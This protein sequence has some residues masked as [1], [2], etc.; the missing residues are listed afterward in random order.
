MK[1]PLSLK[2]NNIRVRILLKFLLCATDFSH[3]S[4]PTYSY[5]P[6]QH[7]WLVLFNMLIDNYKKKQQNSLQEPKYLELPIEKNHKA[8]HMTQ[9]N[10]TYINHPISEV[11]IIKIP[12]SCTIIIPPIIILL[13]CHISK[14]MLT[15]MKLIISSAY[16]MKLNP[17]L[18]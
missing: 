12:L 2:D 14:Q 15:K 5:T 1:C 11:I 9:T 7:I 3:T 13:L 6:F 16:T 10:P 8:E 18:I 17:H 4:Q